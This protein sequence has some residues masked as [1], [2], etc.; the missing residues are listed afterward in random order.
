[1]RQP[2]APTICAR[3]ADQIHRWD[4]DTPIEE[5]L[6]ALHDIVK[7]GKARY[8]GDRTALQP[9]SS[10]LLIVTGDQGP[11]ARRAQAVL[12]DLP[13]AETA[14]LHDYAG[15]TWAD[16]A[17]ERGPT[18]RARRAM[19]RRDGVSVFEADIVIQSAKGISGR[20]DRRRLQCCFR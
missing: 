12:P 15:L 10:R 20:R 3:K 9:L 19:V 17:A 11:G 4:Y 18:G 13:R 14:V 5:T 1:L 8:I 16:I 2:T 6:E 7:A